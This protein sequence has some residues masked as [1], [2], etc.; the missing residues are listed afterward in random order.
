[1]N[2]EKRKVARAHRR[3]ALVI[4]RSWSNGDRYR[5]TKMRQVPNV[6][7]VSCRA[8]SLTPNF[9]LKKHSEIKILKVFNVLPGH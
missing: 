4:I 8:E 5:G 7:V 3:A 9:K 2:S 6:K 1:M